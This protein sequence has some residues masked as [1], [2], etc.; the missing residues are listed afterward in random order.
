MVTWGVLRLPAGV[1]AAADA[2]DGAVAAGVSRHLDGL[3]AVAED[4]PVR[5]VLAR[6]P[7]SVTQVVELAPSEATDPSAADVLAGL[8]GAVDAEH[9]AVVSVRPLADALKRVEGDVVTAGIKRDGLLTPRR[10]AVIDREALEAAATDDDGCD[11]LALLLD[12]GRAVRVVPP[13]GEPMTIR[14]EGA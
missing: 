6:L 11:A 14:A 8:M 10:L 13:V 5:E 12:A 1:D 9:A 2:G 7:D 3:V 4:A